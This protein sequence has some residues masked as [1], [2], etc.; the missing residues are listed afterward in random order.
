MTVESCIEVV[1]S[2]VIQQ[3]PQRPFWI[4]YTHHHVVK[5]TYQGHGLRFILWWMTALRL[6]SL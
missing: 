2:C 6:I 3:Q 4:T 5:V 1:A